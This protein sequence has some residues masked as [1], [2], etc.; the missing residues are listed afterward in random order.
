VCVAGE[1]GQRGALA[2]VQWDPH[3]SAY[4]LVAFKVSALHVSCLDNI[5]IHALACDFYWIGLRFTHVRVWCAGRARVALG[6]GGK[7]AALRVRQGGTHILILT[8]RHNPS[9]E[10]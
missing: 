5:I 2:D 1:D 6:H 3:S 4:M 9:L 10:S 7:G 8:L